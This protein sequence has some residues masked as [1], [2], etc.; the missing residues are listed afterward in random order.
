VRFNRDLK[1]KY[2]QLIA[3]GK[4]AKVALVAIMRKLVI[5]ANALLRD[6]RTWSEIRP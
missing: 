2:A 3:A 1:E 5:L 6:G 4:P